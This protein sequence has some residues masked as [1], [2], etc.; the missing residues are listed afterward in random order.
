TGVQKEDFGKYQCIANNSIGRSQSEVA[1]LNKDVQKPEIVQGPKNQSASIGSNATFSC[2][3]KGFPRPTIQWIK[4]NVSY[5]LQANPRA[6]VT[7][8][9]PTNRSQ[10]FITRVEME[11]YGNYQCLAKNSVG[12]SHSGEAVLSKATTTPTPVTERQ[13]EDSASHTTIIAVSCVLI[14]ALICVVIGFLWNRCKNRD[15]IHA[16]YTQTVAIR[17]RSLTN[18]HTESRILREDTGF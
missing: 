11:D 7:L 6:S 5:H 2:T 9:G 15:H 10:L 12:R 18:R 13:L 14:A 3:A 17:L 4:D 8:D 1:F 16:Q